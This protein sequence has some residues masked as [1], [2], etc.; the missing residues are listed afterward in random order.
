LS[1]A[2]YTSKYSSG[3]SSLDDWGE[4]GPDLGPGSESSSLKVNA[5][6]NGGSTNFSA[7]S[8]KGA[9]QGG[10]YDMRQE[11]DEKRGN[12]NVSPQ[13]MMSKASSKGGVGK[14]M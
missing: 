11:W 8:G 14:A 6:S 3:V 12:D 13:S 5:S 4:P 10:L 1:A 9:M 2:S 7:N